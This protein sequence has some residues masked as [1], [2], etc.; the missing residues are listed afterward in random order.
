MTSSSRSLLSGATTTLLLLLSASTT[1]AFTAP[2]QHHHH[3]ASTSKTQLFSKKINQKIDLDSPKVATIETY[4]SDDNKKTV[5]CRCWKSGTFPLCDGSHMAHNKECGDNVGPLIVTVD[6]TKKNEE[7]DEEKEVVAESISQVDA[8]K[9]SSPFSKLISIFK[10]KKDPSGLTTKE[11]LKKMGLAALLSY[12]FVS[13]M[14][15]AITLSVSWFTHSKKTGLSPL[16]PGQ[17]KPFLAV[18]AGFY[19]FTN[20]I[21]PLRFGLSVVVAR[22]FESF[23][24]FIERKS[25]LGRKASIGVVVF[26]ANVCGTFAAMGLGV[27]LASA[28]SGVPIF[29]PK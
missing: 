9:K 5:Y 7:K 1:H 4:A 15:Y 24:S 3:H 23:V 13:N 10:P 8:T 29:P 17:W 16:A 22:Y 14:S 20:I 26:L 19:V 6:T 25:G 28:M 2:T 11:K 18:Y 12:G 21:R 27:S